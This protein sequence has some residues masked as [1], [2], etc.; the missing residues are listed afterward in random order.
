[1][2]LYIP[3]FFLITL[4]IVSCTEPLPQGWE[5][6]TEGDFDYHLFTPP[7]DSKGTYRLA[8]S[9]LSPEESA[10]F[11]HDDVQM[12]GNMY[13]V[14]IDYKKI[15]QSKKQ[16]AVI[17]HVIEKNP[18][19][20]DKVYLTGISGGADSVL[21]L[22]ASYPDYFAA[23]AVISGAGNPEK[24]DLFAHIP[25]QAIHYD[26]DTVVP[27][28]GIRETMTKMREAGGLPFFIEHN[29]EGHLD[30]FEE[31]GGIRIVSWLH[32]QHKKRDTTPPSAPLSITASIDCEC[33]IQL[34]WPP[35]KD[36]ESGI[37]SYK[38]FRNLKYYATVSGNEYLDTTADRSKRYTYTVVAVNKAGLEAEKG[39][40]AIYP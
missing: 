29:K 16:K 15:P 18:I 19:N 22:L 35:A 7:V 13:V 37:L 10:P 39:V 28:S 33:G 34:R 36:K 23:A 30:S 11:T 3:L 20:R 9:F 21:A 40:T 26:G 24:A 6:V 38:V 12:K 8:V 17:D 5:K 32:G 4:L 1:M 25:L 31:A 14:S 27:V 2:K